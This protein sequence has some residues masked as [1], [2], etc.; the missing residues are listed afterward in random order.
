MM[1]VAWITVVVALWLTVVLLIVVVVG[2]S[3]RVGELEARRRALSPPV[4]VDGP[5]PGHR[6]PA[7]DGLERL[8]GGDRSLSNA[9]LLFVR[10]S[11]GACRTL[12]RELRDGLAA[13]WL[14]TVPTILVTDPDGASSFAGLEV[15][16][17]VIERG[18]EL[19]RALGVP[20][21]PFAVAVDE[22]AMVRAAS[23]A[24]TVEQLRDLAAVLQ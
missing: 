19:T 18:W 12:E 4:P 9:L 10:S 21:T 22:H 15:S 5:V 8:L 23:F 6:L 20:G 3:R 7:V 17:V 24:S 1:A 14:A 16:D 13:D 11:C 2:L